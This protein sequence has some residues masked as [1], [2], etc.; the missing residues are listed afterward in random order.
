[1]LMQMLML[2][3]A[4]PDVRYVR[5]TV[6]VREDLHLKAKRRGVD[7]SEVLN[8]SLSQRFDRPKGQPHPLLGVLKGTRSARKDWRKDWAEI[9]RDADHE[10]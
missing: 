10:W 5:T 9:H 8:A 7:I 2:M 4:S 1:M 6:K 3:A